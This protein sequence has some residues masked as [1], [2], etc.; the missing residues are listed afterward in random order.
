MTLNEWA[1]APT[2]HHTGGSWLFVVFAVLIGGLAVAMAINPKLQWKMNRWQYKNA[3]AMEPSR[4]GLLMTR[5][6][7]S[8]VAVVAVV[9]LV[10]G[11]RQL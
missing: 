10:I 11:I 4:A 2:A 7:S 8:V 1:A 9:F 6:T 5:A 3:A